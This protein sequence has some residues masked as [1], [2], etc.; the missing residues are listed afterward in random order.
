MSKAMKD[1][2]NGQ[3]FT[4]DKWEET[5]LA[6]GTKLYRLD[7]QARY[8][9]DEDG[10]KA[11]ELKYDEDGN[12]VYEGEYFVTEDQ[13]KEGDYITTDEDGTEHFDAEKYA[14]DMQIAPYDKDGTYKDHV[15]VYEV[16][17][18]IKAEKGVTDANYAY[19]RGGGEQIYIPKE[20]QYKMQKVDEE[21]E[22]DNR[23][24]VDKNTAAG[25][26]ERG[27]EVASIEKGEISEEKIGKL[28]ADAVQNRKEAEGPIN[29]DGINPYGLSEEEL[30]EMEEVQALSAEKIEKYY[31]EGQTVDQYDDKDNWGA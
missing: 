18:P 25:M 3:G 20:E 13:L 12:P 17:E 28:N 11:G 31:Q 26:Q 29:D 6:P 23:T 21:Y 19:G 22:V 15:S 5:Q 24:V 9:E 16:K 27:K 10:H 30:A 8:K 1:Q 14:D 7:T 2:D 4:H